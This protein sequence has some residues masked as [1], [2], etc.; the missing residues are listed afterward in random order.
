MPDPSVDFNFYP[1]KILRVNDRIFFAVDYSCSYSTEILSLVTKEEYPQL[2]D[3]IHAYD[4][5]LGHAF[6]RYLVTKDDATEYLY[7]PE[8]STSIKRKIH[9]FYEHLLDTFGT[10]DFAKDP[11]EEAEKVF[12]YLYIMFYFFDTDL[13]SE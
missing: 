8:F 9:R 12:D 7:M 5:K 13:L 3:Y 1:S 10:L 11:E 2:F 4:T 6:N